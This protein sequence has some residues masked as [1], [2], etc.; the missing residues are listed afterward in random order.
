[1]NNRELEIKKKK[2][3][4]AAPPTVPDP[5]TAWQ[6]RELF[7]PCAPRLAAS[8]QLEGAVPAV[9]PQAAVRPAGHAP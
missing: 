3:K 4:I 6:A 9:R 7:P 2:K 1:L 5:G 8:G